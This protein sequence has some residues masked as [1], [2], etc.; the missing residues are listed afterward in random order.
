LKAKLKNA[1]IAYIIIGGVL[2]KM[3]QL[4]ATI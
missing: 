2:A 1:L 3:P 4:P